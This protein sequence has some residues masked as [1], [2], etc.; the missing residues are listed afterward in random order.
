MVTWELPD[1]S[2][3]RC[4]DLSIE[5]SALR[6]FVLRFMGTQR[7]LWDSSTWDE[8]QL[9]KEF[10]RRFGKPVRVERVRRPDG[11]TVHTIRPRL[12]PA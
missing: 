7:G 11:I 6:E 2:E 3:V 4:E 10:E 1:G 5:A 8:G 9:A 12:A